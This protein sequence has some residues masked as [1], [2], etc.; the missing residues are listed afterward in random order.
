MY[1]GRCTY[2]AKEGG[3]KIFWKLFITL[4]VADKLSVRLDVGHVMKWEE[5][6]KLVQ[7][8]IFFT[9]DRQDI[10]PENKVL[11]ANRNYYVCLSV[12]V[13]SPPT[14]EWTWKLGSDMNIAQ[15]QIAC[16]D[17]KSRSLAKV[18]DI[19]KMN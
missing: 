6:T 9:P 4:N 14:P 17:P 1:H 10:I 16:Y 3:A 11:V 13:I 12:S 7:L 8:E 18:K 19:S 15:D 5:S 2:G